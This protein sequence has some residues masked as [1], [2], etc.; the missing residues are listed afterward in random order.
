MLIGSQLKKLLRSKTVMLM[1]VSAAVVL[2][3]YA[4]N[5]NYLGWDNIRGIMNAMSL[6]GTLGVGMAFLLMGGGI[7][8]AA[9]AEGCIGAILVA[10]LM[11][12]G[13]PWPA[14]LLLGL[15]FGVA[16]GA[17]NAF[18]VNG[19]NFMGFIATIA[20]S[21]IYSGLALVLTNNQNVAINNQAFWRVGSYALFGVFPMAFVILVVLIV[22]YGFI[23]S[24]TRFG[25]C[26]L[27]CGGNRMAARLAGVD[28]KRVTTVLYMNCGA[29]AT[30]AGSVLAAR[31]HFAS[32]T[33]VSTGALDAI[34]AAVLGGVSF[35]GGGGNIGG[36]LVGLILL[37][38]FNN[39]LVVINLQAYWQIVSQGALLIIALCVDFLNERAK[40]ASL[41]A[42]AKKSA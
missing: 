5:P 13:M 20:M 42:A 22:V 14:A 6:S 8:L 15:V 23:L 37:N 11:K 28:P 7:D 17:V 30:L 10:M 16:A 9:G 19:L 41:R 39:G 38:T 29:L 40:A 18:L 32:P 34:T 21:S 1:Y 4:I 26:I 3:F 33:A 12:T 31:M 25:R 2:F 27:L 35:M 36:L 24:K